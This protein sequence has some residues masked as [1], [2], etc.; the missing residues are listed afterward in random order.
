MRHR[1]YGLGEFNGKLCVTLRSARRRNAEYGR[2]SRCPLSKNGVVWSQCTP[3]V[4]GE[5]H[6]H[7]EECIAWTQPLALTQDLRFC[8]L[9]CQHGEHIWDA[10]A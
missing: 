1:Y 10:R 3:L 4:E 6:H 9:T 5:V 7:V 8:W 2:I